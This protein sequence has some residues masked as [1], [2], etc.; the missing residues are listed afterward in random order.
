MNRPANHVPE[1]AAERDG[2]EALTF[3]NRFVRELPGDTE[4]VNRRRQVLDA[5]HSRVAPTPVAAT[6]IPGPI[7]PTHRHLSA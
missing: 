2:L 1:R 3:D 4:T 7:W 5:C 6:A